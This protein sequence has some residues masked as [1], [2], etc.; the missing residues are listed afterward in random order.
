M[1]F[2]YTTSEKEYNTVSDRKYLDSCIAQ[3]SNKSEEGLAELY[4]LTSSSVYAYALSILK[5]T[6]DAEDIMHDCYINIYH[7]AD[8]YQ[9]SGKPMA[10][11]L[12]IAKNLCF[13]KLR[14][15]KKVSDILDENWESLL[16][17]NHA[18]TVEDKLLIEKCMRI[19]TD[20]ERQIVVLHAVADFKHREIADLMDLLLPTVL[21][22][23]NRAVKKLKLE[24]EKECEM[25]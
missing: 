9:S 21:S 4:K 20:E 23:Y 14:E 7:S 1:L 19:L 11:I 5:N 12:T 2:L 10:W 13:Q 3:I 17:D 24:L 25:E 8:R 18:I 22:K 16:M 15:K 6:F